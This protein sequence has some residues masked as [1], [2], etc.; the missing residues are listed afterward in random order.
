MPSYV[1]FIGRKG[2]PST[3]SRGH[4]LYPTGHRDGSLWGLQFPTA[5]HCGNSGPVAR[6]KHMV[7]RLF[8]YI[9]FNDAL[10]EGHFWMKDKILTFL[11]VA[12]SLCGWAKGDISR[13]GLQWL[14]SGEVSSSVGMLEWSCVAGCSENSWSLLNRLGRRMST[15]QWSTT[16]PPLLAHCRFLAASTVLGW[17]PRVEGWSGNAIR[18][19]T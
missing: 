13:C 15:F 14:L 2:T 9:R 10:W 8:P 4:W 16:L 6:H 5:L 19:M 7:T 1:I 18:T 17:Y 11:S 3:L 12:T